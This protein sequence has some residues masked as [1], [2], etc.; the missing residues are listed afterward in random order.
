MSLMLVAK[1]PFLKKRSMDTV[2][3][4][5]FI[6]A[7]VAA[8]PASMGNDRG[9]QQAENKEQALFTDRSLG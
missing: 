1:Y 7:I 2:L 4:V 5:V 8:A 9:N 6:S 3:I